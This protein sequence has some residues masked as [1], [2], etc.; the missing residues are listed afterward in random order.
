MFCTICGNPVSESAAFCAKCGHRLAK[1]TQTAKAPIPVVND[2]ELQAAANALKAKS[3]EKSNPEA[4]ISQYR[5]SIAALRDLSQESPNQ[6]QQ[7]NFPYLFNRLTMLMEK[8]KKYKKAL[9]ETGVYESLPRRQRHAGKKS[10]ITAIDN[11]KLRLISKQRKLRLAD[12]A[13]K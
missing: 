5:K 1:V 9:D 8:Q 4:A 2:K 6:P 7:G 12:K 13:R 10:D 3:L 11:R